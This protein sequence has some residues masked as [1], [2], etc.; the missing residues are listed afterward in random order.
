M[1]VG[2][3]GLGGANRMLHDHCR[4]LL[5]RRHA[6][7]VRP[8]RLEAARARAVSAWEALWVTWLC[9]CGALPASFH[10]A[11]QQ[12]EWAAINKRPARGCCRLTAAA[13]QLNSLGPLPRRDS[14]RPRPGRADIMVSRR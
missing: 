6:P 2:A 9:R 4:A 1:R 5:D 11:A 13:T 3:R 12:Y 8:W 7:S 10:P 14:G